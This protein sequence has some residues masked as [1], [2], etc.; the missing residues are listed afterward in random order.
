MSSKAYKEP[1]T[2]STCKRTTCSILD[3]AGNRF[4]FIQIILWDK[5][6]EETTPFFVSETQWLCVSILRTL[7]PWFLWCRMMKV[8]KTFLLLPVINFFY[9]K[10]TYLVQLVWVAKH[11]EYPAASLHSRLKYVPWY[12]IE[13]RAVH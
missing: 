9:V 4:Q 6:L 2:K 3:H 10:I 1:N 11:H 13:E 12:L 5:H 7:H 8:T